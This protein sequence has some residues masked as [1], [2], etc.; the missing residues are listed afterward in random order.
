MLQKLEFAGASLRL[1]ADALPAKSEI[2]VVEDARGFLARPATIL[3]QPVLETRCLPDEDV[4]IFVAL[5]TR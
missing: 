4:T 3:Q 5:R 2:A 1:V